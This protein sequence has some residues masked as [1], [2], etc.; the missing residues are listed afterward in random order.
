LNNNHVIELKPQLKYC[1]IRDL[2]DKTKRKSDI[3]RLLKIKKCSM[4]CPNP[5]CEDGYM[6]DNNG[7]LECNKCKNKYCIKCMQPLCDDHKC[8]QEDL[9]TLKCIRENSRECP[10]CG[11]RIQKSRGCNHMFCT[12]C[13]TGF[14][15]KTGRVLQDSEQTNPLFTEWKQS[16]GKNMLQHNDQMTLNQLILHTNSSSFGRFY[17]SYYERSIAEL[18][19]LYRQFESKKLEM[20]RIFCDNQEK[21]LHSYENPIE[22]IN[23][24]HHIN[25]S[26]ILFKYLMYSFNEFIQSKGDDEYYKKCMK[27]IQE[28]IP[29]IE[30]LVEICLL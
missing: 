14:C 17:R 24:F 28:T 13:H 15:Y 5:L 22:I 21:I 6:V 30:K 27:R 12:V 20:V 7:K 25:L 23:L 19:K 9:D 8:R 18:S 26:N 16:L 29:I 10:C 2:I 3:T 1:E 11:T 4:A